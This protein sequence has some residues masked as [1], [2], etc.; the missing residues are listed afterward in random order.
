MRNLQ[1]KSSLELEESINITDRYEKVMGDSK[2]SK[3]NRN[4]NMNIVN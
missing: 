2:N 1:K 3:Y 4:D